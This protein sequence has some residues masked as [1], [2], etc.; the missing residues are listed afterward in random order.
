MATITKTQ[1]I[2]VL[3]H[4]LVTNPATVLGSAQS[5]TTKLGV[6]IA[7][8]HASIEATANT[9]PG[10]FRVQWSPSSAD[11]DDWVT[12]GRYTPT[13]TAAVTE[14]ISGTE[15]AD[16]DVIEV[17]STT[18]FASGDGLYILDAGTLAD[19]EWAKCKLIVTDTSIDLIDGLTRAKDSSDA[20]W[21]Q[22]EIFTH[23]M[24]LTSIG[25]YR[26]I[27]VHEGAGAN[28][29]VKAVATTGDSIG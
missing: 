14:A 18:G 21:N 11:D 15:A 17:A 26:V 16:Q 4:Q 25:R 5:V 28:V 29:H 9:N 1:N 20:I 24:D 19:S 6:T 23:Q 10:E 2:D 8:F 27:F 7:M 12:I 13:K 3:T 22:A